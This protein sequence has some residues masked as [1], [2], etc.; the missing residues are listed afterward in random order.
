MNPA[1]FEF[2][3]WFPNRSTMRMTATA[4]FSWLVVF[5]LLMKEGMSL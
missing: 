4:I 3:A 1:S 5:L 2:E